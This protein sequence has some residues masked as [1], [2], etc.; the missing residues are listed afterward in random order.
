[1]AVGNYT[2]NLKSSGTYYVLLE[3]A[4]RHGEGISFCYVKI[5]Y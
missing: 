3:S 5:L 1:M 4:N 2:L